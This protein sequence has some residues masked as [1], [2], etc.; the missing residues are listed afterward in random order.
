MAAGTSTSSARGGRCCSATPTPPSKRLGPLDRLVVVVGDGLAVRSAERVA[1]KMGAVP[2]GRRFL[3]GLRAGCAGRGSV[4]IF[5]EV[6][7]G[8]RIGYGGA[9]TR[10]RLPP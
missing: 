7:T 6:I 2:P 3:E 9:Q 5:D 1:A 10:W 4:L 8:F